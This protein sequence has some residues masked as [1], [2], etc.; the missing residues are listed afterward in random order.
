MI[1]TV[2]CSEKD[3][4]EYVTQSAYDELSAKYKKLELK[5]RLLRQ[6]NQKLKSQN[7]ILKHDLDKYK[8]GFRS[9]YE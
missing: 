6:Q 7:E 1:L 5:N 9:M 3:K 4:I 8:D 2:G